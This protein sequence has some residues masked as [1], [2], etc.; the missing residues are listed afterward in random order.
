MSFDQVPFG[1]PGAFGA[2]T[3]FADNPEPRCPCL[4]I[5]D[6]SGSMAGK[7]IEE[8]ND[9]IRA[10]KEELTADPM[11]AK[12]VEVG[13][14][15]FG[16]VHIL[17]DFQT[18]DTFQPP[19]LRAEGGTPMGAAIE[20]GLVMLEQRK[21]QYRANGISF[22]RPWVFLI[23]DGGPTDK[24]KEAAAKV[25]SGEEARH[26]SFF[27]VGVEGADMNVLRQIAVREPLKLKELRFRDLF[28]WLSNSLGSVSRSS[29]GDKIELQNPVT[30]E[31]WA[32]V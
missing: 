14:I 29:V 18:T 28:I 7:A 10:F 30:P 12:R 4:L 11:A 23:T 9:G 3:V 26:F 1:E 13:I 17:V 32:A 31:G 21:Q 6:T 19:T 5:L 27:A 22:Y 20:T 15:G 25:K 16:P 24:W 2:D 8:L